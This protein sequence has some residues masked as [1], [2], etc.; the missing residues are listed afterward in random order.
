MAKVIRNS[1]HTT[2]T[3]TGGGAASDRPVQGTGVFWLSVNVL[4]YHSL[5]TVV[6]LFSTFSF[7][8]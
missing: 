4:M 6:L 5:Y 1:A 3:N 8:S 7:L 2:P